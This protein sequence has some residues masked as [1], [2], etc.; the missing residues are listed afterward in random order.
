MPIYENLPRIT[1][2]LAH[3]I[4]TGFYGALF[5]GTLPNPS[6][7][8]LR[9][10]FGGRLL[11]EV[12]RTRYYWKYP[13]YLDVC[14]ISGQRLHSMAMFCHVCFLASNFQH[15]RGIKKPI[16]LIDNHLRKLQT[17]FLLWDFHLLANN[18]GTF[19]SPNDS[20]TDSSPDGK[21]FLG[22]AENINRRTA[23]Q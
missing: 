20:K 21:P 23:D 2:I 18:V 14:S 7:M 15:G 17:I 11:K 4:P 1:L 22:T 16:F 12:I 13:N 5:E 9:A 3:G 10:N 19:R 8:D 6:P